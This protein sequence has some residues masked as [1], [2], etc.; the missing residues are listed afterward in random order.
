[1][2][3]SMLSFLRQPHGDKRLFNAGG[4]GGGGN[5]YVTSPVTELKED[6]DQ[7]EAS[8]PLLGRRARRS[9]PKVYGAECA[10]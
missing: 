1:M 2:K 9:N 8:S 6:V 5:Y 7:G 10:V 4:G 3:L